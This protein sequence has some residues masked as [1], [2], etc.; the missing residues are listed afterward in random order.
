MPVITES[1]TVQISKSIL[2]KK[3]GIQEQLSHL[4]LMKRMSLAR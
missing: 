4:I 1:L 2:I 3:A